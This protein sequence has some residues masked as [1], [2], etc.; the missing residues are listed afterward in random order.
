MWK[1]FA[2]FESI[3]KIIYRRKTFL[4]YDNVQNTS[5]IYSVIMLNP[6][7][8]KPAS[9]ANNKSE[10]QEIILDQT[11][12]WITNWMELA[13][14]RSEKKIK[15]GC[16]INIYNLFDIRNQNK[17]EALYQFKHSCNKEGI[18]GLSDKID[19]KSNFVWIAWGSIT[20]SELLKIAT[21]NENTI[22]KLNIPII[23]KT[24]DESLNYYHPRYLNTQPDKREFLINLLAKYL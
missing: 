3:Q 15:D 24:P 21:I 10:L 18:E 14:N 20:D 9:T 6:G 17:D 1:G 8:C 19:K 12:H 11:M 5:N 7:S 13:F 22:K 4:V 16:I 23:G 2:E